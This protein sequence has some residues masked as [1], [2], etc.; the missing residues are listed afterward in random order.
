LG[1]AE[2][3]SVNCHC[4]VIEH[5]VRAQPALE[6]NLRLRGGGGGRGGGVDQMLGKKDIWGV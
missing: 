6:H 2:V 1:D 4:A 5:V 3:G